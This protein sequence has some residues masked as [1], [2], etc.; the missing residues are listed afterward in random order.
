MSICNVEVY[1]LDAAERCILFLKPFF[2][3]LFIGE[4]RPLTLR[5]INDQFLLIHV[6]LLVAMVMVVVDGVGVGGSSGGGVY[7]CVC[8]FSLLLIFLA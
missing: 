5:D 2:L 7:M 3:C 4:L 8:M 1:F 6:I